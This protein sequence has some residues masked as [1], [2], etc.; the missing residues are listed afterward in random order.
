MKRLLLLFLVLLATAAHAGEWWSWT[1]LDVWHERPWSGG[2]LLVNRLDFEDG[3]I[4]QM[5]SPRVRY[6]LLPWL[7]AGVALSALNIEN[8]S[9]GDRY[10]QF[11]PELE[12]NP[13]FHFTDH[14]KLECRNRME[15]RD[16]EREDFTTHR[17]RHRLQ[18]AWTL[19]QPVGPVTRLFVSNEWLIDLHKGEWSENRLVPA[20]LTFKLTDHTDL[21][22]FYML[23]GHHLRGEWQTEQVIVTYLRMRF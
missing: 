6:E 20:G 3:D 5:I 23:L 2:V 12:L 7:E 14:L 21:D 18:L 8:T 22:L 17:S 9:T 16:N 1:L 15:W 11:R 19:P 4:V 13:K 10:W